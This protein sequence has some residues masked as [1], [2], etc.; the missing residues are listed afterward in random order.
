MFGN[1]IFR[2]TFF[3]HFSKL[4]IYIID[5]FT[6]L[7]P[8]REIVRDFLGYLLSVNKLQVTLFE[9]D[10][11]LFVSERGTLNVTFVY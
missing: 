3:F 7:G 4:P 8:F 5:I 6:V 9:R 1:M 11:V 10:T 2:T